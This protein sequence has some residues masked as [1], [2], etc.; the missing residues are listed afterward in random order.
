MGGKSHGGQKAWGAKDR[1]AKG[2]GGKRSGGKRLGGKRQGGKDRG[3]KDRGAKVLSPN[4][5]G[6]TFIAIQ[7]AFAVNH[8]GTY[9]GFPY[10]SGEDTGFQERRG[11]FKLQIIT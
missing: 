7:S 1:G 9:Y 6:G 3:A 10:K 4:R 8:F 2:M 5:I 11:M